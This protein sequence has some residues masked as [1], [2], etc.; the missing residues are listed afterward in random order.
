MNHVL[1]SSLALFAGAAIATQAGMN[2]QLGML[3]KSA[4]LA[5]LVAFFSSLLFTLTVFAVFVREMPRL[6]LVKLVPYHLWFCGGILSTFGITV[7]YWLIPRM[8]VG[9]MI[10]YALAGQVILGM[11][12]S[13]FGWFQLPAIPV[14]PYKLFGV[15]SLILGVILI[16]NT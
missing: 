7:F 14:T 13:H 5:T 3:L 15:M 9:P 1:L 11:I 6:E 4:L 12:A 16:N 2:A 10:S 8:G